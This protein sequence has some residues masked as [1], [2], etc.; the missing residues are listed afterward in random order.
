MK[1]LLHNWSRRLQAGLTRT[2]AASGTAMPTN[3]RVIALVLETT[4]LSG[5]SLAPG[6]GGWT[7]VAADW[8][9][10][11]PVVAPPVDEAAPVETAPDAVSPAASLAAALTAARKA[12]AADTVSIGLPTS[13]LLIRV[14][15]L[16]ALAPDEVAG[17]V[18]LQM[19]KLSPFSGDEP[20]IGWEVLSS[21][22]TQ[23]TV[24]AAAVPAR[25][26]APL[27]IALATAGMHVA[28]IDISLLDAWRVL[29]DRGVLEACPGRQAALIAQGDE[30]DLLVLDAGLP[31][32][33]RGLGKAVEDGDLAR[34]VA[35]SLFQTEIEVGLQPLHEIVVI[36]P[37]AP[38]A[39]DMSALRETA[40]GRLRLATPPA[41]V[42]AAD[43]LA[44]RTRDAAALD[45]T[46]LA[47][48]N[49][50]QSAAARRRLQIGLGAAAA[51]WVVLAGVLALGPVVTD[52]LGNLQKRREAAILTD[53]RRVYD[54]R[55]RVQL[56]RRYTDRSHSLLE[57]LRVITALQP[58]GIELSSLTYRREDG[59]KIAG[60]TT[61]PAL[62]YTF[63]DQLRTNA[64]FADCKPGGVSAI[65]GTPKHRF[66]L[67]ALF[68]VRE[69]T[70]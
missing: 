40:A 52:Q 15:R 1:T 39:A 50:E 8:P 5:V 62:V 31:V 41:D 29:R 46:P 63:I 30:W 42:S 34:E 38:S 33:A 54:M 9:L 3:D 21:D 11:V 13:M 16:P 24:F 36:S 26:M 20:T 18:A 28:R 67:D 47:W 44:M 22:E 23:T 69:E 6:D 61:A 66:D 43:G 12:F 57:S 51:I 49:R 19:D 25:C 27:D 48:R 32:L 37:G 53:Y 65:P 64:P 14:L 2:T 10:V 7:R 4:R 56:I 55:E 17:A 60:E 35:L 59:C 70:P 45:L 68:N 58:E